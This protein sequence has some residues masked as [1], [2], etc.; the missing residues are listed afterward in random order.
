LKRPELWLGIAIVF[1]FGFSFT[2]L[3]IND[4]YFKLAADNTTDRIIGY[5]VK[6]E[7]QMPKRMTWDNKGNIRF[8]PDYKKALE[9]GLLEVS[10]VKS[11]ENDIVRL[12]GPWS[13]RFFQW[14]IFKGAG[15][16]WLKVAMVDSGLSEGFASVIDVT[17]P[18]PFMIFSFFVVISLL[19]IRKADQVKRDLHPARQGN[20]HQEKEETAD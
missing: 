11:R 14:G 10:E 18:T 6:D 8:E 1:L 12:T 19:L 16:T 4:H 3:V 13:W 15:R 5:M 20:G 7:A 9:M 2:H 17:N